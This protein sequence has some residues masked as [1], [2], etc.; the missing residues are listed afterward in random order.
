[1]RAVRDLLT[2]NF[3]CSQ[4]SVSVTDAMREWL[5]PLN[6]HSLKEILELL[7]DRSEKLSS[8]STIDTVCRNAD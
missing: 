3:E 2:K 5:D 8:A 7:L 4:C 1:M 6:T